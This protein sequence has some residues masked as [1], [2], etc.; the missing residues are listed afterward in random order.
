MTNEQT[1]FLRA[2]ADHLA[3]EK[4]TVPAD[5]DWNRLLEYAQSQQVGGMLY[6]QCKDYLA[7][8][9][10]LAA[11]NQRLSE[12]YAAHT[13]YYL[14]RMALLEQIEKAFTEAQI[15][16]YIV[17]GSEIAQLYPVPALRSMGDTDIV[18][19]ERDKQRAH[20]LLVGMGMENTLQ[21]DREW[22]YIKN[23]LLFEL[24]HNLL[25]DEIANSKKDKA[26]T[27]CAWDYT[28]R[29]LE[30]S[31]CVLDWSFHFVFLILHLKKHFLISGVGF[32]QFMDIAL[33]ASKKEKQLDWKWINSSL[34]D[35]GLLDYAVAC[36]AFC[37]RWFHM[38]FPTVKE[39]VEE[40]FFFSS[41]EK[42]FEDGIFGSAED[43]R[44]NIILNALRKENS[45]LIAAKILVLLHFVFP[46]YKNMRYIQHY[47]FLNGRPWLLPIA[48]VYRFVRVIQYSLFSR[49][50]EKLN[51]VMNIDEKMN[52]RK[53]ILNKWGL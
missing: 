28:L 45:N 29:Q 40:D 32:R 44:D 37:K 39:N 7:A 10:E 41:T 24:H 23:G 52:S 43:S 13:F 17:K 5:L 1:F 36:M 21:K 27:D 31:R 16:Y 2:L 15:P 42:I 8:S 3:G 35:L 9:P 4:T 50:K 51:E 46:S 18:V 53:Q 22:G 25:Y 34:R 33:I 38:D 6:H 14:N 30:S 19:H 12:V 11:V 26:F 47:S 48:W 49:G 20:A